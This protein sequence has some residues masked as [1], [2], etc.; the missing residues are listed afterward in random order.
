MDL[1]RN[2][3]IAL[4]VSL[5]AGVPLASAQVP[6]NKPETPAREFIGNLYCGMG[7][8]AAFKYIADKP[9]IDQ[10]DNLY[11]SAIFAKAGIRLILALDEATSLQTVESIRVTAPSTLSTKRGIHIGSTEAEVIAAYKNDYD[12]NQS[13][14]GAIVYVELVEWLTVFNIE[15]GKVSEIWIGPSDI[16]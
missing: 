12:K 9:V 11:H 2:F 5:L 3:F 1:K 7:K 13:E 6:A 14:P 16:M 10:M 15:S 4:L 8:D